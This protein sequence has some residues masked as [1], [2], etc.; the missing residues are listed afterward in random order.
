METQSI[1]LSAGLMPKPAG[2]TGAIDLSAGFQPKN[3]G[4]LDL[5]AGLVQKPPATALTIPAGHVAMTDAN[6]TLQAVPREQAQAKLSAGWKIGPPAQTHYV[7][8]QEQNVQPSPHVHAMSPAD[9][10]RYYK[11]GRAV[12]STDL[13][14]DYSH[15]VRGDEAGDSTGGKLI[16]GLGN[17]GDVHGDL[18]A[19]VAEQLVRSQRRGTNPIDPKAIAIARGAGRFTGNMVGDPVNLALA[20]GSGGA[21]PVVRTL[22]SL[23]FAGA[24]GK[25]TVDAAGELGSIMDR[26]DIP[27]QDKI[28]AATQVALGA[29]AAGAA[30]SHGAIEPFSADSPLLQH[31]PDA[32]KLT[33]AERINQAHAPDMSHLVP[34]KFVNAVKAA[35]TRTAAQKLG[36][37]VKPSDVGTFQNA[38]SVVMPDVK[39]AESR[40]GITIADDADALDAISNAQ[41]WETDP[42]KLA[43]LKQLESG[44]TEAQKRLSKAGQESKLDAFKQ[45]L[46]KSF[47]ALPSPRTEPNPHV[48]L[49]TGSTIN[50]QPGRPLQPIKAGA[51]QFTSVPSGVNPSLEP[52][53]LPLTTSVPARNLAGSVT[54]A[55]QPASLLEMFG[56]GSEEAQPIASPVVPQAQSASAPATPQSWQTDAQARIQSGR[57][58][59]RPLSTSEMKGYLGIPE[60]VGPKDV[61]A[62]GLVKRNTKG[63]WEV[64]SG[65][66]PQAGD[67]FP[68]DNAM[69]AW[70]QGQLDQSPA[71]QK[72][73]ANAGRIR[74]A[75][76]AQHNGTPDIGGLGDIET[77]IPSTS[78]QGMSVPSSDLNAG[79]MVSRASHPETAIT[80]AL[81]RAPKARVFATA[82]ELGIPVSAADDHKTLIP[83]IMDRIF[84]LDGKPGTAG[85]LDAFAEHVRGQRG[86]IPAG[87]D[88][89]SVA[90]PDLT[91][92]MQKSLEARGVSPLEQ[93]FGNQERRQNLDLRAAYDQMPDSERQNALFISKKTGLPNERALEASKAQLDQTH[94]HVTFIDADDFKAMNTALGHEGVDSHVLPA[95]GAAFSDAVTAERGA[96]HAFHISGDELQI[97]STSV[98]S[99]A[100]AV[101]RVKS[102]MANTEFTVQKPDGSIAKVRGVKFSYGT[103]PNPQ[104][105][106][107]AAM[108]NK[109]ARRISGERAGTRDAAAPQNNVARFFGISEGQ[110]DLIR[111]TAGRPGV[112][113]QDIN[114]PEDLSRGDV[115]FVNPHDVNLDPSR[116]QFKNHVNERGITNQFVGET[117]D[118]RLAGLTH[119]F[120]DPENGKLYAAEGHHRTA[121]A[122]DSNAPRMLVG[123]MDV[124]TPAEAKVQA[125]LQN[126]AE[127]HG[128]DYDA[129]VFLKQTGMS[130][131]DLKARHISLSASKVANGM[132]L[133]RLDNSILDKVGNG[134]ISESRGVAI[135]QITD[136]PAVQE[137]VM[138]EIIRAENY[139]R[140]PSDATVA[141]LTRKY[142]NSQVQVSRNDDLFGTQMRVSSLAM[143]ESELE[144]DVERRLM[145]EGR[146]FG[147]ALSDE[148]K[149]QKLTEAGN[150]IN[151]QEN[152]KLSTAARQNLEMFRKLLGRKNAVTD[153][154]AKNARRLG[155][156][157]NAAK[158]KQE[159]FDAIKKEIPQII[160][161]AEGQGGPGVSPD[162][163][164]GSGP[165]SKARKGIAF[166]GDSGDFK[167]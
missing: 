140:P 21:G 164:T 118:E 10:A 123:V 116:F 137:A 156:K 90:N 111:E 44:I 96:S 47:Q 102:Q 112:L 65:T 48:Q 15:P 19:A 144:S 99:A 157:E 110:Q 124:G 72:A 119:V 97:R 126:L 105:A 58:P 25:S 98:E 148:G 66:T 166:F 104:A 80:R 82:K 39:R 31:V 35:T 145:Q 121:L 24:M 13:P 36:S 68:N 61:E 79:G 69:E 43:A 143:Q 8:A 41:E 159:N 130:P 94:K 114:R 154:I 132:A 26:E 103:G 85:L 53:Q 32:Y 54:A 51:G 52:K 17:L 141:A 40:L 109:E 20:A 5:S 70:L 73:R 38:A 84:E 106:E 122:Q 4:T 55:R 125:A 50:A 16:E 63:L 167:A 67:I 14:V 9:E 12:S 64:Q 77:G 135:G 62:A 34:T 87:P 139:G 134:T 101:E 165:Q 129:G 158:V 71:I 113:S 7:S 163:K 142:A 3:P 6:N 86:E 100:R 93:M 136:D 23:G 92:I 83:Q 60:S 42:R 1:D 81:Q 131:A 155:D 49:S 162:K 2:G 133:A 57:I 29:L 28:E 59:N 146:L 150:Q 75:E 127:G 128:T 117:F 161:G 88:T 78:T 153:V 89:H 46:A 74:A 33:L 30:G 45:N 108:A 149:A 56:G 27:E 11:N 151:T 18:G 22:S 152:S 95:I 160:R 76:E 37:A 138:K 107:I 120:K 91:D 115:A 147:G